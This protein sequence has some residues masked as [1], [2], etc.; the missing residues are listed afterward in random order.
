MFFFGDE[1]AFFCRRVVTLLVKSNADVV[2]FAEVGEGAFGEAVTAFD[3][4]GEHLQATSDLRS[5]E[6]TCDQG[7]VWAVEAKMTNILLRMRKSA[8]NCQR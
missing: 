7:P 6:G 8:R 4:S 2:S 1:A 5:A 3:L